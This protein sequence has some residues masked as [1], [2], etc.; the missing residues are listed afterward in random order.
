VFLGALSTNNTR[1]WFTTHKTRYESALKAP[2]MV[3]AFYARCF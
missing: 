3:A 2:S 1:D